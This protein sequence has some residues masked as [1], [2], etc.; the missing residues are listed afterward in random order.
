MKKNN[1]DIV[2]LGCRLNIYEGEVI[3]SLTNQSNLS[4]YT[5]INSCS[6]T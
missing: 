6:V 3:K 1:I 2:N 5:I 4:N